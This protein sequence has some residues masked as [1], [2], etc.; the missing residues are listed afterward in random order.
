MC[1]CIPNKDHKVYAK[2]VTKCFEEIQWTA[3]EKIKSILPGMLSFKQLS[4]Y[5]THL[6]ER[7]RS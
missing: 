3:T 4:S 6:T 1:G 7:K 5:E 2:L